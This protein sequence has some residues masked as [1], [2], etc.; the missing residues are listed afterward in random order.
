MSDFIRVGNFKNRRL[1]LGA[2]D[3]LLAGVL[4]PS[5]VRGFW[6]WEDVDATKSWGGTDGRDWLELGGR[7]ARCMSWENDGHFIV[8][9]ERRVQW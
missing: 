1:V 4:E 6:S 9:P 3:A 8:I 7:A 2:P 5:G